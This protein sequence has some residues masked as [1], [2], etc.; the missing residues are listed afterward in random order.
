[1]TNEALMSLLRKNPL[2]VGCA[3]VSLGLIA[4]I[5]FRS[6]EIPTREAELLE[7]SAEGERH[8]LNLKN[9]HELKEQFDTLVAA[10]KEIDSRL[11]RV[12]ARAANSEYFYKIESATGVKL[13]DPRQNGAVAPKAGGKFTAV[14]FSVAAQGDL[15][16]LLNFLHHLESGEHYCRVMNANLALSGVKRDAPMTLS[17]TLEVLGLP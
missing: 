8:A 5:Y 11:I 6:D 9:A 3:L 17:L 2:S 15:T 12:D 4:A 7:K 10:N 14:G 16:Q 13:I 1:M